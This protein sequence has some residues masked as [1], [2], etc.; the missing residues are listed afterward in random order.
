VLVALNKKYK[1]ELIAIVHKHVPGCTIYLFG[2]RALDKEYSG[3]DIDIALDTGKVIDHKKLLAIQLDFDETTIPMEMDLV[4]LC[5]VSQ[6]LKD[7]IL[8]EG[9]KWTN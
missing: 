1:D 3:S 5:A 7:D 8:R 6:E 4:D 9:V 2:S